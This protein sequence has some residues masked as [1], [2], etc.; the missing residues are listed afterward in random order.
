MAAAMKVSVAI[1]LQYSILAYWL[2]RGSMIDRT[3]RS[4]WTYELSKGS[5]SGKGWNWAGHRSNTPPLLHPSIM[6]ANHLSMGR[7]TSPISP[8]GTPQ[9]YS[10]QSEQVTRGWWVTRIWMSGC[11][12]THCQ[13]WQPGSCLCQQ[14]YSCAKPH[15]TPT[16]GTVEGRVG[17]LS[18]PE[19]LREVTQ[20]P[21]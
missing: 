10:T 3:S 11:P 15:G 13:L 14:G 21:F 17:V 20:K 6:N 8:T 5:I 12:P 19:R 2:P 7:E 16:E 18:S 9:W 4:C 1:L